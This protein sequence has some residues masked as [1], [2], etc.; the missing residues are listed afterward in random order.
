MRY[1]VAV[2]RAF[3]RRLGDDFLATVPRSPGVYRVLDAA[4]TV[5]YVG[6]AI[7]LRRRLS[8]YRNATRRKRHR[9]MR[10]IVES[11][12]RVEFEPCETELDAE[13]R[14]TALIQSLTPKWNVVGAFSFL[15]PSIGLGAP[16]PRHAL[17]AFSTTPSERPELDWHGAYRSRDITGGAFFA[18]MRLLAL[19]G[20]REKTPR[21][22]KGTRT[23]TFEVRRLPSSWR[24]D[25]SAFLRGESR[26]ALSS[27]AIALLDKPRARRDAGTVQEDLS[28]LDRF[29]RFE[30]QKLASAR[31]LVGDARWPIPQIDR[32]ALF[33]RAR[34][35]RSAASG[36]SHG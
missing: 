36:H 20:H 28:A 15:Y 2:T 31:H 19:I 26:A 25:W 4:G 22:P 30:A 11:A 10:A 29:Y 6:K 3:D 13:L 18:L 32:D 24:D 7:N 16:E 33:I 27:L 34:A 9:K 1:A 8:Q 17:F 12:A 23:W 5:V 21:R 35:L 14:E